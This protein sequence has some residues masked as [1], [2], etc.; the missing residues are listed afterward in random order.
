MN[1]LVGILV[2]ILVNAV[3]RLRSLFVVFHSGFWPQP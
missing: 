3:A 2:S 1:A